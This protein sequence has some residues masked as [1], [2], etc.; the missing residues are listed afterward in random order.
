MYHPTF[1]RAGGVILRTAGFTGL[2]QAF[3]K[4]RFPQRPCDNSDEVGTF[5]YLSLL[6]SFCDNM[7]RSTNGGQSWNSFS[8]RASRVAATSNGLPS[9]RPAVRA[10]DSNISRSRWN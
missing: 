9:I 2:F 5:F 10:T 4:Q 8:P 3:W 6:Q 7:Y 1:G